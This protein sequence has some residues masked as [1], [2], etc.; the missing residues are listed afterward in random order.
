MIN[1]LFAQSQIQLQPFYQIRLRHESRL[2]VYSR[3]HLLKTL[4]S[5][6]LFQFLLLWLPTC[7]FFWRVVFLT[8]LDQTLQGAAVSERPRLKRPQQI[9]AQ[10]RE[11]WGAEGEELSES[12]R[13]WRTKELVYSSAPHRHPSQPSTGSIRA[14]STHFKLAPHEQSSSGSILS[15]VRV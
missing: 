2:E 8:S 6:F 4:L 15:N 7:V 3:Q 12:C 13:V 5:D 9:T 11:E 10:S 14:G 1:L